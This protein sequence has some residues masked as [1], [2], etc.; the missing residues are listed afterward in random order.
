MF[1]FCSVTNSELF[2][3]DKENLEDCRFKE[4]VVTA[5]SITFKRIS[6]M[7]LSCRLTVFDQNCWE[8]FLNHSWTTWNLSSEWNFMAF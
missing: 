7:R 1:V 6:F 2:C 3:Q 8:P 4:R 5:N